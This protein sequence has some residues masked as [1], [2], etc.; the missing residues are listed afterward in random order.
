MQI[1]LFAPPKDAADA[2]PSPAAAVS[3]DTASAAVTFEA[4]RPADLDAQDWERREQLMQR[5]GW[6]AMT[7]IP[8][9]APYVEEMALAVAYT[10]RHLAA[11]GH[12]E[13]ALRG[14]TGPKLMVPAL[15]GASP[16][17]CATAI[18]AHR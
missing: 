18:L 16:W 2:A 12:D 4:E 7:Q 1:D 3:N 14:V 9:M 15:E 6:L 17:P 11:A 5:P 13:D 10:E 8:S